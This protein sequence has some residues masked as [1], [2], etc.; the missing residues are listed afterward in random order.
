MKQFGGGYIGDKG[1]LVFC[2]GNSGSYQHMQM[3]YM[4]IMNDVNKR[5]I[6]E[7]E[8]EKKGCWK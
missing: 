5:K 7:T 6:D 1:F 4:L 3:F 8:R 2:V